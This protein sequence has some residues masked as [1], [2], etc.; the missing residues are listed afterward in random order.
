MI[1]QPR[2]FFITL[3]CLLIASA[4]MA[5]EA[6]FFKGRTVYPARIAI[7]VVN[8]SDVERLQAPVVVPLGL[9]RKTDPGLEAKSLI[10]VD[11][12]GKSQNQPI[13]RGEGLEIPS[14]AD[15]LDGDGTDDELSFVLDL[16]AS[17]K[18]NLHLYY[19]SGVPSRYTARVHAVT[20]VEYLPKRFLT[21]W[22]SDVIGFNIY[23]GKG[24]LYAKRRPG[25]QYDRFMWGAY[26][27]HH[28]DMGYGA[29]ILHVGGSMGCGGIEV[30][31]DGKKFFPYV[32][33]G[34]DLDCAANM[35]KVRI[36]CTGPVRTM[37]ECVYDTW[38]TGDTSLK[39]TD[40][41]EIFAGQRCFS[42]HVVV[43]SAKPGKVFLRSG[44]HS[45]KE[46]AH[47]EGDGFIG[48][49]VLQDP[50]FGP[51]G[52]GLFAAEGQPFRPSAER[53]GEEGGNRLISFEGQNRL[54]ARF[55]AAATWSQGQAMTDA[56]AWFGWL[57][58]ARQA[59]SQPPR[60]E[61]GPAEKK[62]P[63]TAQRDP[64]GLTLHLCNSTPLDAALPCEF[65][66]EHYGLQPPSKSMT[67]A[68]DG[69]SHPVD[70]F[71]DGKQTR[72]FLAPPMK[73]ASVV[74]AELKPPTAETK[75]PFSVS[76]EGT[77]LRVN[78]GLLEWTFDGNGLRNFQWLRGK[79]S[80]VLADAQP[81]GEARVV[82]QGRWVCIVETA[83]GARYDLYA[84][85]PLW[86]I[87]ANDF[88]QQIDGSLFVSLFN[89]ACGRSPIAADGLGKP[90]DLYY[91]A[92]WA[93]IMNPEDTCGYWVAPSLSASRL[94][95]QREGDEEGKIHVCNRTVNP[96]DAADYEGILQR[97]DGK[98]TRGQAPWD[99]PQ[100][101]TKAGQVSLLCGAVENPVQGRTRIAQSEAPLILLDGMAF[102]D[103]DGNNLL[104]TVRADDRNGNGPDF[105]A[106]TWYWDMDSD[107]SI[108]SFYSFAD[109]NKDGKAEDLLMFGD[110]DDT[111]Q[112]GV[113]DLAGR[114]GKYP[115]VTW[116]DRTRDGIFFNNSF[117]R[118][119]GTQGDGV[120]V[121][122]YTSL[123]T[124]FRVHRASYSEKRSCDELDAQMEWGFEMLDLDG[125]GDW[126]IGSRF[127]FRDKTPSYHKVFD[128]AFDLGD[129]NADA[130][131][132]VDPATGYYFYRHF[133]NYH[134][135]T[136]YPFWYTGE[137]ELERCKDGWV[138]QKL[139][140]PQG[141]LD[142]DNNGIPE[143]HYMGQC[144]IVSNELHYTVSRMAIDL[145]KSNNPQ[146]KTPGLMTFVYHGGGRSYDVCVLP[147]NFTIED[148]FERLPVYPY[149]KASV[150]QDP[151]GN[152]LRV[153][154][155]YIPEGWKGKQLTVFDEKGRHRDWVKAWYWDMKQNWDRI[156]CLWRD[157]DSNPES[158]QG[159]Q[160]QGCLRYDCSLG[161]RPYTFGFYHDPVTGCLH[162]QGSD[163]GTRRTRVNKDFMKLY[164][165]CWWE[166][167]D[168][169]WS[170][171]PRDCDLT[172]GYSPSFEVY[173]DQ[174]RDGFFDTYLQDA[175]NDGRYEKR[176]WY[177]RSKKEMTA[178]LG[179]RFWTSP[180]ELPAPKTSLDLEDYKAMCDLFTQAKSSFSKRLL[181]TIKGGEKGLQAPEGMSFRSA[182]GAQPV[183]LFDIAHLQKDPLADHFPEGYS[184][185]GTAFSRYRVHV[186]ALDKPFSGQSLAGANLLVICGMDFERLP[187]DEEIQAFDVFLRAGGMAVVNYPEF[188]DVRAVILNAMLEPYAIALVRDQISYNETN[189][190]HIIFP[191]AYDRNRFLTGKTEWLPPAIRKLY[192]EG[193]RISTG[194]GC[195]ALLAQDE[196]TILAHAKVGKGSL[197]VFGVPLLNNRFT[198]H[199]VK[200]MPVS[201][202][203]YRQNETHIWMMPDNNLFLDHFVNRLMTDIPN[204]SKP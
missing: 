58:R 28:G 46:Q 75:S 166:G 146:V 83:G 172:R 40:R 72:G 43:E 144:A 64:T 14:Q 150:F 130:G 82:F 42:H 152:E 36:V 147:K 102:S 73:K 47:R 122:M 145:D 164:D 109:T 157:A 35:P 2:Q 203:G 22:E 41:V 168:N 114:E 118:G 84:D 159:W 162:F 121:Q 19:G 177:D 190:R 179:D 34:P 133:P 25:L 85:S 175:E 155:K 165:L 56:E 126:D 26:D 55:S 169:S 204:R 76:R 188:G 170:C 39:V 53:P 135:S 110:Y 139:D 80:F 97:G 79:R 32:N 104:D 151:H 108:Q 156:V 163:F 37:L 31:A 180:C 116:H 113:V 24:D 111:H 52:M 44:L 67:A 143:I 194:P 98:R 131:A 173:F 69:K 66:F 86:K 100:H 23:A 95:I 176:L 61:V 127:G 15:D 149:E 49:W 60:V 174:D 87:T 96:A 8:P 4:G 99:D 48:V 65:V 182:E 30:S 141:D 107:G 29:D 77:V 198:A 123:Y 183:I 93:T 5:E 17:E 45:L 68:V 18:R 92:D 201:R 158:S 142:L 129:G 140:C 59:A 167:F 197:Y 103:F 119:G 112:D 33:G 11:P 153:L 134:V 117:F 54:E 71:R 106:D 1:S 20:Q 105:A 3:G 70:V 154:A 50:Q 136:D 91:P 195:E 132:V 81:K 196:K 192:L 74:R 101:R 191:K 88:D 94:L 128:L 63:A 21:G 193:S 120:E 125:D 12:A 187:S 124:A 51:F 16:K 138:P 78:N 178:C 6:W 7:T 10:V 137:Q 27:L 181:D 148:N 185:L 89:A 186:R 184:R 57:A 9:L 90:L 13:P 199:N 160:P 202:F 62:P 189:D 115:L 200:N 171:L 161:G 38:K